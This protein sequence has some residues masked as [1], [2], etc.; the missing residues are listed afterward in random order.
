[1]FISTIKFLIYF[2]P[3]SLIENNSQFENNYLNYSYISTLNPFLH[4]L[5]FV[6]K[7]FQK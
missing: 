6:A 5:D 3:L 1:M 7:S 2:H 4:R